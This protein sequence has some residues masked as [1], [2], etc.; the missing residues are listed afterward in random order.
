M[1][2]NMDVHIGKNVWIGAGCVILPGVTIGDNTVIGAGSIVTK[3][4]PAG[5][6]AEEIH[7]IFVEVGEHDREYY[8][9]DRKIDVP[10]PDVLSKP[11]K[12]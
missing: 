9:R 1:Q 6:K 7:A 12:D 5:V 10:I 11:D 2:Y 4:I 3:D 8:Y